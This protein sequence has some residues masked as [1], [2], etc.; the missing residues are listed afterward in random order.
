MLTFLDSCIDRAAYAR[1]WFPDVAGQQDPMSLTPAGGPKL[2]I[3][4]MVTVTTKSTE[5]AKR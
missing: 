5:V 4:G 1:S 2:E 3:R